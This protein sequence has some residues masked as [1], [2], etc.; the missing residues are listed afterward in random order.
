VLL[1]SCE[2]QLVT[3]RDCMSSTSRAEAV[4]IM[5]RVCENTQSQSQF[6]MWVKTQMTSLDVSPVQDLLKL[7][8]T[9]LLV[10]CDR[11]YTG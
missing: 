6:L 5:K 9:C 7:K 1:S 2:S 10:L 4:E 11:L 8:G 3:L